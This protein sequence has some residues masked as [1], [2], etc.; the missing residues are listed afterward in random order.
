MADFLDPEGYVPKEMYLSEKQI[1][2]IKEI[3]DNNIYSFITSYPKI[4]VKI[5]IFFLILTI[6]L[7]IVSII[8]LIAS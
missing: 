1:E 3:N 8:S 5:G 4:Y 6:I 2:A 7:H